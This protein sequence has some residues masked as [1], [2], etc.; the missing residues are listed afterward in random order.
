M[1]N[2]KNY[3]TIEEFERMRRALIGFTIGAIFIVSSVITAHSNFWYGF[4]GF[5]GSAMAL[6]VWM[7]VRSF[8]ANPPTKWVPQVMGVYVNELK[9]WGPTVLPWISSLTI[10]YTEM[11][12]GIMHADI[13]VKEMIP[14]DRSTVAIPVHLVYDVDNKNPVQVIQLGGLEQAARLLK[15]YLEKQ[16]RHWVTHPG[17]GPQTLGKGKEKMTLDRVRG[18][19]NEVTNHILEALAKDDIAVIHSDIPIEALMGYFGGR[20]LWPREQQWVSRIEGLSETEK[21]TLRAEVTKRME[22]IEAIRSGEKPIRI[23]SV[24]LLVRQM[25]VADIEADGPSAAAIARVAE[26]NFNAEIN[27]I[28]ARNLKNQATVLKGV[29]GMDLSETALVNNGTITKTIA[30]TELDASGPFLKTA[31][32]LGET[33]IKTL[34]SR[35]PTTNRKEVGNVDDTNG[36]DGK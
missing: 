7:S 28:K 12:G 32:V 21:A 29:T 16:I 24:G 26:A 10:G 34:L 17:K 23:Q 25:V 2:D 27:M 15:E 8:P 20:Q 19:S 22:D 14:G 30:K 6:F 36:S 11:P 9:N 31:Q 35:T 4:V 3:R 1:A 5:G 18:M 33:L 13:L